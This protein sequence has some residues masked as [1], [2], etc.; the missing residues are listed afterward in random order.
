MH[1]IPSMLHCTDLALSLTLVL[2][3]VGLQG[4]VL[5]RPLWQQVPA[6]AAIWWL[7]RRAQ[8]RLADTSR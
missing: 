8:Q 6:H 7:K 2:R 4:L 1:A 5:A 3:L